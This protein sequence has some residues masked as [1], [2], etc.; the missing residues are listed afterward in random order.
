MLSDPAV[1]RSLSYLR[2]TSAVVSALRAVC[3][4]QELMLLMEAIVKRPREL[5]PWAT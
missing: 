2:L 4:K 3:T 1:E 5:T